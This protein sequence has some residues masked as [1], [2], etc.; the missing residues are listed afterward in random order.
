MS[1]IY[2]KIITNIVLLTLSTLIG[3]LLAYKCF[4]IKGKY[5]LLTTVCYLIS[6]LYTKYFIPQLIFHIVAHI[7]VGYAFYMLIS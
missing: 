3:I 6:K 5:T 7:V 2:Y 4:F 1:K